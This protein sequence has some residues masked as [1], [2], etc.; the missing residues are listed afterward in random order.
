VRRGSVAVSVLPSVP[1]A[2]DPWGAVIPPPSNAAGKRYELTAKRSTL[3]SHGWIRQAW[4]QSYAGFKEM[5]RC[6][7]L[8]ALLESLSVQ[9]GRV[10]QGLRVEAVR[11]SGWLAGGSANVQW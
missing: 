2:T 8:S 3:R 9:R 7:A 10:P 6:F 11:A 4:E 1:S 5:D